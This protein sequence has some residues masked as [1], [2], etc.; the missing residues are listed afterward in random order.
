MPD[1]AALALLHEL[2]A[3]QRR[4]SGGFILLAADRSRAWLSTHPEH[5]AVIDPAVLDQLQ[6]QGLVML[7]P[8]AEKKPKDIQILGITSQGWSLIPRS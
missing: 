7:E 1:P 6:A 4:H 5:A 8:Y 3:L 2:A